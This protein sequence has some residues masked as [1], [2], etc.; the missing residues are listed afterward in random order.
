MWQIGAAVAL[1]AAACAF[2]NFWAAVDLGYDT[3]IEGK[4][5]IER[6]TYVLSGSLIV[7]CACGVMALRRRR[8]AEADR[9]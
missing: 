3:T 1:A 8:S 2:L 4:K 9:R 7:G 6:W 5:I